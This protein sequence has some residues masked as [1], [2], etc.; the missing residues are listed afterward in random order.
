MQPLILPLE[1][2]ESIRVNGYR[3]GRGIRVVFQEGG[4]VNIGLFRRAY[5]VVADGEETSSG[6][7]TIR[8]QVDEDDATTMEVRIEGSEK[9]VTRTLSPGVC[10][11]IIQRLLW[12]D[13]LLSTYDLRPRNDAAKV[14]QE[15]HGG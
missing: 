4:F 11:E 1:S 2:D 3:D 9:T 10:D 15:R 6:P 8:V 14:V 13:A 5:H 12:A 7:V